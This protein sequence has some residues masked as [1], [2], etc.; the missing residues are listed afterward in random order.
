MTT[1]ELVMDQRVVWDRTRMKEVEEAKQFILKYKRKGHKIEKTDGTI[2]ERFNPAL[3]EVII[4][5]E[6]F[7]RGVMKILSDKGDERLV[8]DMDNGPEA[9]QAK[10]RFNELLKKGHKA[11]SVDHKGKKNR[12]IEE[13][14]VEA[15]EIL[16]VPEV[17]KG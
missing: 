16:M 1:A 17:V 15:E 5:A 9:M 14:D 3:E 13:F 4:K 7:A 8:W 10:K 11:Y 2:M 12:R 6:R